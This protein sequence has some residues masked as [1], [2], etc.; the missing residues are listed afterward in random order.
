MLESPFLDPRCFHIVFN[1]FSS[2]ICYCYLFMI[3]VFRKPGRIFQVLLPA[4]W[5]C[6]SPPCYTCAVK[7]YMT[8]FCFFRAVYNSNLIRNSF[9]DFV[10]PLWR[11]CK[12]LLLWPFL[13]CAFVRNDK[14]INCFNFMCLL[15][16]YIS[17]LELIEFFKFLFTFQSL[18]FVVP[19]PFQK[20]NLLVWFVD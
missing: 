9:L 20:S 13:A 5:S 11:S 3:R 18:V 14:Q 19:R 16:M 12:N 10:N 15:R 4:F 17:L 1:S 7:C 8:V 6:A 2:V